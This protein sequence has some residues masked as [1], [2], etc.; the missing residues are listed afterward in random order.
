MKQYNIL[1]PLGLCFYSKALYRDVGHNWRGFNILYLL[2]VSAILCIASL[3]LY[4][5]MSKIIVNHLEPLVAQLPTITVQHGKIAIDKP[6]PYLIKAPNGQNV[7]AID[8]SGQYKSL[9][10]THAWILITQDKLSFSRNETQTSIYDLSHLH[11]Y[12][13]TP[14]KFAQY[15][16][17]LSPILTGIIFL[18]TFLLIFVRS[19]GVVFVLAG[20]AKL[21]THTRLSYRTVFRLGT[22]AITPALILATVLDLLYMHLPYGWLV[23]F[24]LTMAYLLYG[25]EANKK[26]NPPSQKQSAT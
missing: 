15:L 14:E 18:L 21:L 9:A 20:L 1:Q 7:I 11:D 2:L 4:Y 8:T 13:Y 17:M 16:R 12:V 6:V 19:V 5:G 23:Y 24:P 25:I 22:I 3:F 26:D 10:E